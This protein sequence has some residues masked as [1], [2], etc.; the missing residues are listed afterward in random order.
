M[1]IEKVRFDNINSLGGH[2]ELNLTHPS[3]TDTGIFV[4]TG[5]TGAG[6]TTLLD[7]ITYAIYGQTA[8][9]K[10]V[11]ATSNEIM[12]HGARFCRAEAIVEK[13]GVRYLFSTEQKRRKTHTEGAAA[14]STAERRVSRIEADG[15]IT[16][17]H[18]N[19]AGVKQLADSLMKYDNFCRCMMLAQGDFA[20]FLKSD[21]KN[22]SE[23]LATIT[24]T[25]IYQRIG[26]KVQ[27][28]VAGLKATLAGVSLLQVMDAETRLATEQ[29][30]DE[31]EQACKATQVSLE[32]LNKALAWYA[33]LDK[34]A[35]TRQ[36]CTHQMEA[37]QA[38]LQHFEDSGQS[39]RLKAAE[40]AQN[41]SPLDNDRRNAG[42]QFAETHRRHEAEQNWLNEHPDTELRAAAE[43]AATALA[44]QQPALEKQLAFLA[45]TVQPQEES[46]SKARVRANAAART[47]TARSKEAA[48]ANANA[49]KLAQE[50]EAAARAAQRA[51]E[52]LAQLAAD[53]VLTEAL[54]AIQTRLKDWQ[55]CPQAGAELPAA[56][57]ITA[58]VAAVEA[59]RN[60]LLSG[61]RREELPL[62]LNRIEAFARL[63]RKRDEAFALEQKLAYDKEAA[64][65]ARATLPP[66][67]KVEKE[68]LKAQE[69]A[70][71]AY[72]IQTISDKLNTL[73]LEFRAGR[74]SHC[75]CCG[76]PKPHDRQVEPHKELQSARQAAKAAQEELDALR[77]AK[78]AAQEKYVA[79]KAACKAA[80]QAREKL[81]REYTD[82][83]DE[84][85]WTG[86]LPP[87]NLG[88]QAEQLRHAI[89]R[90]D[91]LDALS[92]EL[93]ALQQQDACRNALH[94]A[95]RPC[96]PQQPA[97][98]ADAAA[99]VQQLADRQKA[100]VK[101]L[102]Q[103]D[104]AAKAL[105]LANERA[106]IAATA[107]A[108]AAAI[109][110][111]AQ[112]EEAALQKTLAGLQNALAAIWQGG[113]AR[114][115]EEEL[116]ATLSSLQK[117]CQESREA[118]TRLTI[119]RESHAGRAKA[120]GEQLP[121]QRD[122]LATCIAAFTAALA[123]HGFADEQ[124]YRAALMPAAKREDLRQQ[125]N[126]L[127][128]QLAATKGACR[129]AQEQEND[130]RAQALSEE[131]AEVLQE[132]KTALISLL[133]E[134]SEWLKQLYAE[135]LKDDSALRENAEKEAEIA[136]TKRELAQWQRLLEILGGTKD[137]FKKYAQRITFNL[138][139]VQANERLRMLT[140]RYT[141]VQDETD[142]L[143]LRV[144][145]RY[146]DDLKGRSCSNLSGGESFIVSLALAL[147]LAQ[148]AGE[149][150]IDTLFLDEGFGTL[151]E[152]AL[153]QV[154]TCLQ[155][156]RAGGKLIGIISHVEALKE[157][158][159]ANI[160]LLPRG[161]TGLSTIAAHSAVVAD[162]S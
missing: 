112:A 153:E 48:E 100:Y 113:P 123:E 49:R 77:N 24:G 136:D 144:I 98:L 30:R 76:S 118:L 81:D 151:D 42:Q 129:Q 150:R 121:S 27:A 109:L 139:L 105:A 93:S 4:I 162:P 26:D 8:R 161:T 16:L 104:K 106:T 69:K 12:T 2:F 10:K 70:R 14:Y 133:N 95:L 11:T 21:A 80:R 71:L 41:V 122:K 46:I 107:A 125:K 38:A 143:E 74:L 79:A 73:Y 102:Q 54:P 154:L 132:K 126:N 31:Q 1:K 91:E 23:A 84:L 59:E 60:S 82:A 58:R 131:S 124:A 13:D 51:E 152:D 15:T 36:A 55:S 148:M 62:R 78:A 127:L 63:L 140:D 19:V 92:A 6:K 117:T 159:P 33:E 5:P 7:A 22:R 111:A 18:S 141:L 96:T 3:L 64:D 72:D 142:A 110:D 120:A 99:L 43:Q 149:T 88:E 94:E 86:S 119:E 85:G 145:D 61:R 158:I 45:E 56:A 128:Q 135:L 75:P 146:Q 130:L 83:L 68:C 32:Q 65:T 35:A 114:K 34:A 87:D 57:E 115:A 52:A 157:R 53:A 29:R 138:L 156:L 116:R 47:V 90:L 40:A 89:R 67:D 25:E 97:R 103:Q 134:Q 101:A 137:G 9:Q 28:R 66:L 39:A 44:E 17:L 155:S 37:A 108:S 50:A 160:E 147:G 20:L